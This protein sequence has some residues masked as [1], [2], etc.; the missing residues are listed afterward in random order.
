M[1]NI[2][3]N[4][5]HNK[6]IVECNAGI[7]SDILYAFSA[8][9]NTVSAKGN[10]CVITCDIS[11]VDAINRALAPFKKDI[12]LHASFVDWKNRYYGKIP[13]LIK[14]GVNKS[15]IYKSRDFDIPHKKIEDECKYFFLPAV[16]QQKYKDGKWDGYIH[17]YKR[18]LRT[19]PT[20][21]LD[22]VISVL[23]NEK[24]PYKIEY[25]YD[26]APKKMF[27]WVPKD[28]FEPSEDQIEALDACM[29]A[30]RCVCKAA[31]GFGKVAL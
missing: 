4:N 31:T 18:Y 16:N 24:I 6:L 11:D 25:T 23:E 21:L 27:D 10:M 3:V 7:A 8:I 26:V 28:L 19:F 5:E 2:S 9:G 1:I 22:R 30:K 20:G 29:K 13:I 12:R 15:I 14:C 17:L